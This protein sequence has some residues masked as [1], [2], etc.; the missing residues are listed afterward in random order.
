MVIGR[1]HSGV[2]LPLLEITRVAFMLIG[3][4]KVTLSLFHCACEETL[5]SF[6]TL[7]AAGYTKLEFLVKYFNKFKVY[8]NVKYLP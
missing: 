4:R 6:V 5:L 2:R 7:L 3:Y 8:F 1:T